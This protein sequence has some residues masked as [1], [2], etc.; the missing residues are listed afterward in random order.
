MALTKIKLLESF[1]ATALQ[2]IVSSIHSD[3]SGHTPVALNSEETS[4]ALMLDFVG[5]GPLA[6]PNWRYPLL[7]RVRHA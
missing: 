3:K 1:F 2:K 4:P 6:F 7:P 5:V